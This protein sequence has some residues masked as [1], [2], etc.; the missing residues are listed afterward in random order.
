MTKHFTSTGYLSSGELINR[1]GEHFRFAELPGFL[2][3]LLSTDGTVTKSLES[4]F[5][6]PVE[7]RNL[8]QAYVALE[9]DAPIIDCT[10]GTQVM[11]RRVE[12]V[13]EHSQRRFASADSLIRTDILPPH[14]RKNLEAGLVGVGEILRECNLETYR[15][16]VDFGYGEVNGENAVWRC[17]RI[18]MGGRAAIQI[19]EHFPVSLYRD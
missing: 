6:E 15:E 14:V 13:G 4:Y 9:A 2:R 7:V 3:V 19:T 18:V 11:Q 5:W 16:I 17:Y 12:L 1:A 10:A 8:G